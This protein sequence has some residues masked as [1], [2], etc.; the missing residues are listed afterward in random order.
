MCEQ[1]FYYASKSETTQVADIKTALISRQ[2]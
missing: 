1:Q 2:I